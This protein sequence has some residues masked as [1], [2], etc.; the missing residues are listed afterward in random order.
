MPEVQPV[1][2]HPDPTQRIPRQRAPEQP[3]VRL[4]DRDDHDDDGQR[5]EQEPAAVE[6]V[7]AFRQRR[8]EPERV[9]GTDHREHPQ[10]ALH[11]RGADRAVQVDQDR[12][13]RAHE[14]RLRP[15][16]GAVV[17]ARRVVP[18]RVEHRHQHGRSHH[19]RQRGAE[20]RA[21]RPREPQHPEHD[22]R[23]D[24][25]ELL[26]D[27]ERPHVP[28]RRRLGELIEVRLPGEDELPVRRRSRGWRSRRIGSSPP[29]PARRRSPRRTGSRPSRGSAPGAGG[30]RGGPRTPARLIRPA[31][32]HSVMSSVVIRKPLSTKKASTP[33]KPPIAHDCEAW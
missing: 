2:D 19:H 6:R 29:R 24:Q 15:G 4:R 21:H 11:E 18:G 32:P 33:R 17:D 27:R 26:L 23:P 12:S 3:A 16:V 25:V 8:P 31:M 20:Q 22:E 28:E 14:Q 10:R 9:A 5:R 30:G 7:A 1:R 13:D